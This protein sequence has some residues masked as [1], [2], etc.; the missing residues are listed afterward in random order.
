ML[1]NYFDFAY[2]ETL[3]VQVRK[4]RKK[5]INKKYAKKFGYKEIPNPEYETA[6]IFKEVLK[7]SK[8]G[9]L[10]NTFEGLLW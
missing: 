1:N 7:G 4:H 2:P 9:D 8:I 3:F 5:R 10:V 6:K